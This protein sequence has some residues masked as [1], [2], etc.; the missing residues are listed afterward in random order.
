MI[1][2]KNNQ[3][4]SEYELFGE[5]L[6]RV[7]EE[8][9]LSREEIAAKLQISPRYLWA[10]EEG[11]FK[12][13]PEGIYGKKFLLEY[14][15]HLGING[16]EWLSVLPHSRPS[17][18]NEKQP[19][20]FSVQKHHARYFFTLP[21]IAKNALIVCAILACLGYLSLCFMR[22]TSPPVLNVDSPADSLIVSGNSL[23][24]SGQAEPEAK[25]TINGEPV[26]ADTAGSFRKNIN[27]K[28]GLNTIVITAQKPYSRKNTIARQVM[29]KSPDL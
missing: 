14:A 1:S 15:R 17:E 13:L 3:I 23:D 5:E 22:V 25:I 19:E 18:R 28:T 9:K 8:K 10:L 2:I 29:V 20:L 21:K 7:R 11:R 12:D 4:K 16:T 6:K 27:L 26:L 24:I